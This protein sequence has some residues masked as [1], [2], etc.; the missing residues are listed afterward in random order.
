MYVHVCVCVCVC[1][2]THVCECVWFMVFEETEHE[3]AAFTAGL[4]E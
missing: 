1:T 2:C 3:M 4:L